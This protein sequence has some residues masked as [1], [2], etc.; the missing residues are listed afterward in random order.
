MHHN[1][2]I[3]MKLVVISEIDVK[4]GKERWKFSFTF[5][6]LS[7]VVEKTVY[8]SS[9]NVYDEWTFKDGNLQC[10][11]VLFIPNDNDEKNPT[12]VP[13]FSEFYNLKWLRV[14]TIPTDDFGH[15]G[16]HRK[17]VFSLKALRGRELPSEGFPAL[18]MTGEKDDTTWVES[19]RSD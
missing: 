1:E 14:S 16:V 4:L 17:V 11:M 12:G 2:K 19:F 10:E 5:D 6:Q 15:D 13:R 18:L 8:D 3:K 9:S 7:F